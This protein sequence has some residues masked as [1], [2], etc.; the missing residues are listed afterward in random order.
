MLLN[1]GIRR[2]LTVLIVERRN[3]LYINAV[4]KKETKGLYPKDL[5]KLI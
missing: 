5:D 3:T 4:I 2:I 1:V